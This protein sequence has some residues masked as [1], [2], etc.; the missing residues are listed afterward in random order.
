MKLVQNKMEIGFTAKNVSFVRKLS[1]ISS[2]DRVASMI[3]VI[4]DSAYL[5]KKSFSQNFERN[6]DINLRQLLIR[7]RYLIKLQARCLGKHVMGTT[8]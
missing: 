8:R 3:K 2:V 5:L 7:R 6:K 4:S 1:S